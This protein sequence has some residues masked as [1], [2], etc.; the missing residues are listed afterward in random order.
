M[1]KEPPY[2]VTAAMA[3][4][5]STI[6]FDGRQYMQFDFINDKFISMGMGIDANRINSAIEE[7]IKKP[8][9]SDAREI[10]L[11]SDD[12]GV[13]VISEMAFLLFGFK[14]EGVLYVYYLI[15]FVSAVIFSYAY[16]NNP[17]A[18][19]LLAAFFLCHRLIQPMIK[20][21]GQLGGITALRCIP[22][23]AFPAL[24]HCLL[25][26][27]EKRVGIIQILLFFLQVGVIVFTVFVR[28][29]AMWEWSIVVLISFVAMA[30][31]IGPLFKIKNRCYSSRWSG[32][33]ATLTGSMILIG[34]LKAHLA[35]GFPDEYYRGDQIVTRVIWHNIYSGFALNPNFVQRENLHVDDFTILEAT[36]EYM[37]NSRRG[38]EWEQVIGPSTDYT[39]INWSKYDALVKEMTFVKCKQYF[40]DC[41]LTI[42]WYKP[43]SL[44]K[45]LL[46]VYGFRK[47]PP[48]MD[49]FVSLH[50]EIGK[51]V[52]NQ[53]IFASE[54]LD[55]NHE[56]GV[57]WI[58][59]IA[60]YAL[61]F[62]IVGYLYP[63]KDLIYPVLSSVIILNIGS[64]APSLIGYPAPHTIAEIALSV[65]LLLIC[66]A[67]LIGAKFSAPSKRK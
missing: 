9:P 30:F 3:P 27:W 17:F 23:L 61:F 36:E 59:R 54:Q 47:F 5:L 38:L 35:Y 4:A 22:I 53:F 45:N 20:Y 18:L 67:S 63:R 37:R 60:L 10:V 65:P 31:N 56:R 43:L 19:L 34:A 41:A 40:S 13:V 28:S 15:L 32:N 42:L 64:L 57:P 25:Y 2:W 21:D 14:V 6:A 58:L 55:L 52:K 48:D 24:L 66:F 50:P 8:L 26:F 46:W 39:T 16:R 33:L 11:S 29:T 51:V 49:V 1:D 12:K 7:I 44:I 62:A